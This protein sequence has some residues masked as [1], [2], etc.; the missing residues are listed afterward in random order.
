M[1]S[2]KYEK[3]IKAENF[4]LCQ[5]TGEICE[6]QQRNGELTY[7]SYINQDSVNEDAKIIKD[8]NR[9]VDIKRKKLEIIDIF[10]NT[11]QIKQKDISKIYVIAGS[12]KEE[13]IKQMSFDNNNSFE[14]M[15]E[16]LQIIIEKDKYKGKCLNIISKNNIF[17]SYF[18]KVKTKDYQKSN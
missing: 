9:N 5:E 8:F 13:T 15:L 6:R 2:N 12:E 14:S 4:Y 10:F 11:T 18:Q 7:S 17:R 3:S 1:E 16:L